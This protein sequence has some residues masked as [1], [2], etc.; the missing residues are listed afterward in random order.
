MCNIMVFEFL[1]DPTNAVSLEEFLITDE[2]LL[3]SIGIKPNF[4]SVT[5]LNGS[6]LDVIE[7]RDGVYNLLQKWGLFSISL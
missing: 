4:I 3:L 1:L 7:V 6:W 5:Y 2:F